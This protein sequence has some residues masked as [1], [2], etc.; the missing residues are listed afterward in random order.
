VAFDLTVYKLIQAVATRIVI[1]TIN[2]T[3][4]DINHPYL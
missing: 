3:L 2:C 1:G 4:Q